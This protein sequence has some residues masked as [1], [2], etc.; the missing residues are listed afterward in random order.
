VGISAA[1]PLEDKCAII[2]KTLEQLKFD[3]DMASANSTV[4]SQNVQDYSRQANS[5]KDRYDVAT[6]ALHKVDK[7]RIELCRSSADFLVQA[8]LISITPNALLAI[9]AQLNTLQSTAFSLD[10]RIRKLAEL[11][12]DK[13]IPAATLLRLLEFPNALSQSVKKNQAVTDAISKLLGEVD[14]NRK[15]VQSV[16]SRPD[17]FAEVH[18]EGDFDRTSTVDFELNVEPVDPSAGAQGSTTAKGTIGTAASGRASK[19]VADPTYKGQ[20]KF[21]QGPHFS[22]SGGL[23]FAPMEKVQFGAIKGIELDTSGNQ[24]LVNGKPNVTTIVGIKE[25]SPNRISPM[26]FLNG[27]FFSF[28]RSS[29]FFSGVHFTLGVTGKNDNKGTDVE[30]L[31]G[32]SLSFLDN[33]VFFTVGAYAGREQK[34]AGGMFKGLGLAAGVDPSVSKSYQ[35]G[36][37]FAVSYRIP[38]GTK[39]SK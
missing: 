4:I 23:G 19:G 27:R 22:I 25:K 15:T 2:N 35:W 17:S 26:V 31:L 14:Q 33:N 12:R 29:S 38:I 13:C 20:L 37:G 39:S 7:T 18:T 5:F 3:I 1:P 11:D 6:A 10:S 24:L 30:F 8:S 32:P 9:S 21:G 28:D 34:L 16:L 36:L